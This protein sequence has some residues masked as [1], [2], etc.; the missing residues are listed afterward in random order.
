[1]ACKRCGYSGVAHPCPTCWPGSVT[2]KPPDVT[3]NARAVTD[4]RKPRSDR[5][6]GTNADRQ[7]AYRERSR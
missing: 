1:M 7:A 3:D 4:K 5:V 6:Y 2:A